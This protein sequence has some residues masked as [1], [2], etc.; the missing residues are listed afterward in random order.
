MTARILLIEDDP[1]LARM[2]ADLLTTD[3]YHVEWAANGARGLERTLAGNFDLLVLDVMLPD[4][5]GHELCREI[6]RRGIGSAILMLTAKVQV[7]DL[8][9]GLR[10]GAD[11]YMARPFDPAE[12]RARVA[13]LVRRSGGQHSQSIRKFKFGDVE[14]DFDRSETR[15]AGRPIDMAA[16]E[17]RLLHYLVTNR[18]RVVTRDEILQRVWDYNGGV[19]SRTIDVH[20]AWLRQKLEDNPQHPKHIETIRGKGYRF[21]E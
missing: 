1:G 11:D 18:Q 3:G 16:K 9:V 4:Q 13:A 19:C 21:T 12:L 7:S 2:V 8:M 6:R 15:K 14:V 10:L 5:S 20:I 17:L